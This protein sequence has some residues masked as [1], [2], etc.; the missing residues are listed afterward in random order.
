MIYFRERTFAT[1]VNSAG[2]GTSA[3]EAYDFDFG[4]ADCKRRVDGYQ[5][6]RAE[7]GSSP[8]TS[9]HDPESNKLTSDVEKRQQTSGANNSTTVE[10][11]HSFERSISYSLILL[12]V[13]FSI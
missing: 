6:S 7:N 5:N 9:K 4:D 10:R 3:Y 12:N 11:G 8:S 2:K 13:F 1:T